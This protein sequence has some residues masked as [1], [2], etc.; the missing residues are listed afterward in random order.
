ML[1]SLYYSLQDLT[2]WFD[3]TK[4]HREN[5]PQII[6]FKSSGVDNIDHNPSPS[7]CNWFFTWHSNIIRDL[8]KSIIYLVLYFSHSITK[9]MQ[10]HNHQLSQDKRTAWATRMSYGK[11]TELVTSL[12]KL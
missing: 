9:I 3:V 10:S 4:I 7:P 12:S 2:L 1:L 6:I 8:G 11:A 5:P